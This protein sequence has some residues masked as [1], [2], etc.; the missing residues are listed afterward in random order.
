MIKPYQDLI[1]KI[2]PSVFIAPSATV[3]GD[4]EIGEDSSIWF[5]GIVRGDVNSIKIAE[6]TNIQDGTLIHVT[7]EFWPVD[8]GPDVTVGHG[9]ILHGCTIGPRCLIGMGAIVLDGASIGEFCVIGA[10]SLVTERTVIPARTLA[11]GS[12]AKPTREL[13]EQECKAIIM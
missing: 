1:P 11:F 8:I 9:A 5:G 3:I 2:H 12:P 4:V 6:R 7:N 13:T 10:G